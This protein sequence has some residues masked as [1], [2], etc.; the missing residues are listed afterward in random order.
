[1]EIFRK[2]NQAADGYFCAVAP[3]SDKY[4]LAK[5]LKF[6]KNRTALAGFV[7]EFVRQERDPA[8]LLDLVRALSDR[9]FFEMAIR[10]YEDAVL[11]D[12]RFFPARMG[13]AEVL[14]ASGQYS[15]SL[16][17]LE[18][19]GSVF[20]D[21]YK[22][23]LT[24]ARV[25]AWA[26]E[27]SRAIK[28]YKEIYLKN[29]ANPV[30]PG[31]AA[32]T[33][34][35]GKMADKGDELYRKI[36]TPT[37]NQE[38]LQRLL[39]LESLRSKPVPDK[40]LEALQAE[41]EKG[42]VFKGYENFFSWYNDNAPSL[43]REPAENIQ[44]IKRDLDHVY[45][46]HK[47]AFL[48]QRSKNLAWNR[49]FAPARRSLRELTEF[50]PGNQE[51]L[52]DLAQA[53]CALGLCDE[54][55]KVYET[56]LDID[57]LHGQAS[58]A[59]KRQKVRS[60]PLVFG[61][62]NF[63][64]EKGR[65]DLA[66]MTRHRFDLGVE[67]PVLCRH[68]F[69]LITH[70]YF[71]SPQKYADTVQATGISLQGEI[72]A[73][74]YITLAGRITHKAYNRDLR[75]R[76]FS[77][78]A[79]RQV[80]ED[81]FKTGLN[82]ITLGNLNMRFNLDNYAA[83]TLGYEKKEEVA[84]AMA[85]AQGIYSDRF[86][87]RLDIYPARKLDMALET[88]YIDYSDKNSGYIHSGEI[89]YAFT[90]HPRTFKAIVSAQYRDTSGEYQACPGTSAGCSITDDFKHPYWTP[91]D[92]W[93][94]AI[95]FEFRHDLAKDF[96]CGAREHFYDLQLTLGTEQDSNNSIEIRGLWQ[97][98]LTDNLGLKALALWH[99]SREWEAMAAEFGMFIRF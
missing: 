51:A 85:L 80:T 71:E 35:W 7:D 97:R 58:K 46:I 27:Y 53:S 65:G 70:K 56:L 63:W 12:D 60:R 31:E 91:Q 47:R 25:L 86:R 36:Y 52:F 76:N 37:V 48:E 30:V 17:I 26:R 96:F 2:D 10:V 57:P 59:L 38:L 78:L 69:K 15:R 55:K 23:E 34:Y 74:P 45:V 20:P 43:E 1:M 11:I 66:R 42:S 22:V 54:E 93:G 62:Y 19:M 13:L 21:S 41:V 73:G 88:E 61:S 9:G 99:N 6:R 3:G 72:K 29:P 98:E 16:E 94:A 40:P 95:T 44:K 84:N 83:L 33:A 67:V 81:S 90:D 28:A 18:F 39:D 8:R 92:Y 5:V 75:I 50:D 14:A 64:K 32:R 68:N 82:D 24:R 89:G 4:P 77:G 49:R 79:G 87:T